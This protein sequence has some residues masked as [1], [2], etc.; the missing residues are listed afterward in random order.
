MKRFDAIII[1]TG[2]AGLS[3]AARFAGVGQTV[4]GRITRMSTC[5]PLLSPIFRTM[6]LPLPATLEVV[7]LSLL[8][9]L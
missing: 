6:R 3:L 7:D 1:G 5:T 4:D 2:Q 8:S 9:G